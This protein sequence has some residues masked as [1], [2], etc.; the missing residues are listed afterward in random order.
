MRFFLTGIE[1]MI[2]KHLAKRLVSLGHTVDACRTEHRAGQKFILEV[3]YVDSFQ[4]QKRQYDYILHMA[5]TTSIKQ[6]LET[7]VEIAYNNIVFAQQIFNSPFRII[8]ASSTSAYELTN[9]Y[10]YSKAFNEHLGLRH[11]NA[12]GM[13]FFNVYGHGN[14]KGIVKKVIDCCLTGEPLTLTGGDQI[15]DFIYIDDVIDIIIDYL[16]CPLKVM[17]VGTGVGTCLNDVVKEILVSFQDMGMNKEVNLFD[18]NLTRLKSDYHGE[19]MESIAHSHPVKDYTPLREG[20]R[21]TIEETLKQR[22]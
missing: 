15:R 4:L 20:I 17:D 22:G 10:A 14:N 6:D 5:A 7:S 21:K 12:I 8:Y 3:N 18:R 16:D 9:V 2:G 11:G 19:Q 1:G 13:R